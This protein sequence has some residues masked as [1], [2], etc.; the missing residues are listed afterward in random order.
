[1]NYLQKSGSFWWKEWLNASCSDNGIMPWTSAIVSTGIP[2][3]GIAE[4]AKRKIF[5]Q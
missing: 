1:M 3:L 2:A 5:R 4:A